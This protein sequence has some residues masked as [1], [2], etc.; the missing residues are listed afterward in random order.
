MGVEKHSFG[1]TSHEWRE[2][3]EHYRW[4]PGA[5]LSGEEF[6]NKTTNQELLSALRCDKSTKIMCDQAQKTTD[7]K[8]TTGIKDNEPTRT[9]GNKIDLTTRVG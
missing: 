4:D 3:P 9:N 1:S 5:F 6:I 8:R 7:K 2:M